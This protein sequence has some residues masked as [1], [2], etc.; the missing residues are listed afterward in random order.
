TSEYVTLT[1]S[2]DN[3]GSI[4]I[5]GWSLQ[6][7]VT[8]KRIYIPLAASPYVLGIVNRVSDALLSPGA[9]AI[10]TSGISPVGVS[11]RETLCTGY[12][13]QTQ[14]FSPA[15]S[16]S[17]PSRDRVLPYNADNLARFG[18][19]CFDYIQTM[20]QCDFPK[21]LP[22]SLSPSCRALL[23]TAFSYNGCVNMF[24]SSQ[25]FALSSWRMYA[26]FTTELWGN[27][28]DILR[29]SDGQGRIVTTVS[30]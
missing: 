29:L 11:F 19:D 24:Q 4:D 12:L 5:S 21:S 22:S 30:Y 6:S 16:N 17:C 28:H 7:A 2:A 10:I 9:S 18:A 23:S 26:G 14:S 8:G 13:N 27:S 25:D 1:A 20:P 3:A 15:L